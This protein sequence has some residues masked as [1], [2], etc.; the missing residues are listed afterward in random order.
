MAQRPKILD[1]SDDHSQGAYLN[2]SYSL[3]FSIQNEVPRHPAAFHAPVL[4][5]ICNGG[6]G[7]CGYSIVVTAAP[8]LGRRII[9]NWFQFTMKRING[10][11]II[12]SR[13]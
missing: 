2:W 4:S 7:R 13:K 9:R 6:G 3:P 8:F 12:Q 10:I 11:H 5:T 1:F